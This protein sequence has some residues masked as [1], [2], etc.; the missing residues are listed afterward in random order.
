M[1]RT[2]TLLLP[3]EGMEYYVHGHPYPLGDAVASSQGGG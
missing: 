2:V 1:F 3:D